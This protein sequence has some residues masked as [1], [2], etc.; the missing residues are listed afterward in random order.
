MLLAAGSAGLG[1]SAKVRQAHSAS[2]RELSSRPALSCI[3]KD[4]NS[5]LPTVLQE[6]AA[7]GAPS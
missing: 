5:P 3:G 7:C 2:C 4:C 1:R 6:Q